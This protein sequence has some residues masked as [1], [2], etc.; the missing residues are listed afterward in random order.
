M[1]NQPNILISTSSFAT[2]DPAPLARLAQAGVNVR[3]NPHGRKLT[4]DESRALLRDIDGLIAG[5]E[6]LDESV[7]CAAPRL[8]VISRV[9]TGMDAVD[10][11]AASARGIAIFNTPDSHTDAVAELALCGLLNGLRRHMISDRAIRIGGWERS[12][13]RLLRGKTVGI[14]GLGKVGKALV[15]LLE[16]FRCVVLGCDLHWDEEFA[17]RYGVRRVPLETLLAAADAISL[18]LPGNGRQALIDKAALARLKPD[19][20][21]VNTARGGLI[22]EPALLAFLQLHPQAQAVLDVFSDEPYRGSLAA[23]PNV[24]MSAHV[25]A[26]AAECRV[27]MELQAVESC[28]SALLVSA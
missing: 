8:K 19:A 9:G 6:L 10:Q 4:P 1:R 16:P 28:L 25:G 23:L 7:L 2:S 3:R 20:V 15:K 22:D 18:H 24:L 14:V 12:M 26:Y 27:D 17:A 5:V 21:L 11:A 13:G